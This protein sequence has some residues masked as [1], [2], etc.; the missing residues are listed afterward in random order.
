MNI[1]EAGSGAYDLGLNQDSPS[2][3]SITPVAD[4]PYYIFVPV[5]DA[6][7]AVV[8]SID[9]TG[10]WAQSNGAT[11]SIKGTVTFTSVTITVI[12]VVPGTS[13]AG[14]ITPTFSETA[15][16]SG[17]FISTADDGAITSIMPSTL[18][19]TSGAGTSGSVTHG[20]MDDGTNNALLAC[21]VHAQDFTSAFTMDAN[22][23]EFA[24]S[25]TTF[26]SG[27]MSAGC[28]YIVGNSDLI[29]GCT[30]TGYFANW[31]AVIVEVA[32]ASGGATASSE[33]TT[34]TQPRAIGASETKVACAGVARVGLVRALATGMALLCA[35]TPAAVHPRAVGSSR[36]DVATQSTASAHPRAIG[37]ADTF[38]G[39]RGTARA[40]ARAVTPGPVVLQLVT[41]PTRVHPRAVGTSRTIVPSSGV[42]SVEPRA[43]GVSET[44]VGSAGLSRVHPRSV[45]EAQLA[46]GNVAC[47]GVAKA[48]PRS[49]A[50]SLTTVSGQGKAC[51]HARDV[52][53]AETV[54][55]AAGVGR[56]HLRSAASATTT[57]EI[58]NAV[59]RAQMR[60]TGEANV[61]S[62]A[63][64]ASVVSIHPYAI[65]T[66]TAVEISTE[67]QI[68]NTGGVRYHVTCTSRSRY[69]VS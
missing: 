26:G 55:T 36:T 34:K 9:G 18:G 61:G 31:A 69:G 22:Y 64:S 11:Y 48:H 65:G 62:T 38:G 68:A 2:T 8:S 63:S 47:Q 49:S 14:V 67:H 29:C 40:H 52:G 45:G 1:A 17:L 15:S 13:D 23:T 24:A 25:P 6:G 27:G 12:S 66:A 54:V 37:Q 56:A 51:V 19:T 21:F 44:I 41:R 32:K 30:W 50:E 7:L 57:I 53:Q 28:G 60:A 58:S 5:E 43:V 59:A 10:G 20:T 4:Q 39:S 35:A 3:G 42:A 33:G 46:S 16:R